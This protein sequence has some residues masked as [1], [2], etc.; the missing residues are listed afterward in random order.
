MVPYNNNRGVGT[1]GR[2]GCLEKLKI[3]VFLVKHVLLYIHVNN[4][5]TDIRTDEL[6]FC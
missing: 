3:V 4:D 6:W 1:I 5:V 2:G